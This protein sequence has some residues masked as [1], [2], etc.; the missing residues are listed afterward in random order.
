MDNEPS[1]NKFNCEIYT[2]MECKSSTIYTHNTGFDM[3]PPILE[4]P[5]NQSKTIILTITSLPVVPLKS[6]DSLN[7]MEPKV[8]TSVR[9]FFCFFL[10]LK[11]TNSKILFKKSGS[12]NHQAALGIKIKIKRLHFPGI[13]NPSKNHSV[14]WKNRQRTRG[15]LGGYLT[16]F[17]K[18]R[19]T[20]IYIHIYRYQNQVFDS[21]ITT[22]LIP[23]ASLVQLLIPAPYSL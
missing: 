23:S 18:L 14:A 17:K 4:K 5:K 1:V 19:T 9:K 16:S 12:K 3:R 2:Y 15:F 11:I 21:L 10:I 22:H 6:I 13:S 7:F 20:G 8:L